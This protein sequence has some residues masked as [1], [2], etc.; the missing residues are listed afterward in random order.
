MENDLP[1]IFSK[2]TWPIDFYYRKLL[3]ADLRDHDGAYI[4]VMA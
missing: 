2:W 3:S 1:C 4:P